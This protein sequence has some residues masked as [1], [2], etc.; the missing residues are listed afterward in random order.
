MHLSHMLGK[1]QESTVW[2]RALP[3]SHS[4]ILFTATTRWRTPRVCHT[5]IAGYSQRAARART[6]RFR[7]VYVWERGHGS[8][9]GEEHAST[10]AARKS[11]GGGAGAGAGVEVQWAVRRD[12]D[13]QRVC[14]VRGEGRGVST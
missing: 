14:L 4:S 13:E 6:P 5:G 3:H 7:G 8:H 10:Q 9:A 11:T 1:D 2:A 12:L